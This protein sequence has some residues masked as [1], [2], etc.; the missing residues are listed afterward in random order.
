MAKWGTYFIVGA[1]LAMILPYVLMFFEA[2]Q[3]SE[4]P[5]FPLF[6]LFSG[7]MGVMIHLFDALKSNTINGS[8]V[9]LL[10]SILTIIYGFSL[11]VLGI[12]NAK[13]LLLIGA[14]LVAVWIMLPGNKKEQ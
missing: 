7:G 3:I 12:P 13:Y 8:A 11:N 4:N 5:I 10:T 2:F 6:S 1:L 9:L 14:L